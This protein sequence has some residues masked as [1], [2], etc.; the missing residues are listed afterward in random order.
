MAIS[1]TFLI[2]FYL[3]LFIIFVIEMKRF[4]AKKKRKKIIVIFIQ[5]WLKHLTDW[6]IIRCFFLPHN[7]GYSILMLFI[8]GRFVLIPFHHNVVLFR[9]VFSF[10]AAFES[11]YI[12]FL[13]ACCHN[14]LFFATFRPNSWIKCNSIFFLSLFTSFEKISFIGTPVWSYVFVSIHPNA[15]YLWAF[16]L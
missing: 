9:F 11:K 16:H 7:F 3:F 6:T 4:D 10:Q 15:A 2:F 14:F 13:V 8:P 5:I 12:E 1:S